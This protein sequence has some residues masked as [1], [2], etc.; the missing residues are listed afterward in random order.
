MHIAN[1]KKFSGGLGCVKKILHSQENE[2]AETE[3]C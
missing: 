1:Y 3:A 2:Q